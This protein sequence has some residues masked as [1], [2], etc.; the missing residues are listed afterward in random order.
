LILRVND[1][2]VSSISAL[3]A[4]IAD[5]PPGKPAKLELLRDGKSMTVTVVPD[6]QPDNIME[7]RDRAN[8][9]R[10]RRVDPLPL[11]LRSLRPGWA[12]TNEDDDERAALAKRN[13]GDADGLLVVRL[14]D[15]AS[16]YAF[17]PGQ[18]LVSVNDKPVKTIADVEQ[19]VRSSDKKSLLLQLLEENGEKRTIEFRTG[20]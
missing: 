16:S 2:D 7:F 18:L 6:K 15:G 9:I 20:R 11:E 10:G 8:S 12:S 5:I 17:E 14:T 13:Y 4:A 1:Q 19:L 3:R